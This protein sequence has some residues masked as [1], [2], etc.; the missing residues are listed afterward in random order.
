MVGAREDGEGALTV[1]GLLDDGD[2]AVDD[3]LD[4]DLVLFLGEDIFPNY[5]LNFSQIHS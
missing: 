1:D 5:N 3:T 2:D 4:S